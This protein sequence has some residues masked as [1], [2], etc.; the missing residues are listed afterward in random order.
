M[1]KLRIGTRGSPLALVQ[2]GSVKALLVKAHPGLEAELVI[3]RTSGDWSSAQGETLLSEQAGGKAQFA[4][5]IE[6]ALL[7]G[8]IDIGVH[9]AKDMDSNLPEGLVMDIF[10]KREDVRDCLF[11]ADGARD[12]SAPFGLKQGAVLGTSSARRAAFMKHRRP[13]LAIQPLRG[14]VQTRL[15]KL[16]A[17]QVGATM[18]ALAGLNRLGIEP[19]GARVLDTESFLPAAGQGAVGIEYR[20][21][22]GN[23]KRL[24]SAIHH[25]ETALRVAAER[26]LVKALGGTCRS[27]IGALAILEDGRMSLKAAVSSLDGAFYR[28]EQAESPVT[29]AQDAE[30]LGLMLGLA[31]KSRLPHGVWE[32]A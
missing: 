23:T 31:L 32:A 12:D 22:D 10:L 29:Q 18:L 15:D 1:N 9:S 5:E 11:I 6:A 28:E 30:A 25:P 4:H 13:D 3:I 21:K 24:L 26:A 7:K 16:N 27:P 20:A 2:A 14:N 19:D 8:E 17:G